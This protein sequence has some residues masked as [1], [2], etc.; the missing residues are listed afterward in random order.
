LTGFIF[1]LVMDFELVED[2]D[3]LKTIKAQFEATDWQFHIVELIS[4][5]TVRLQRNNTPNRLR[6]K[7]SK[8]NIEQSSINI[9]KMDKQH[10]M[11]SHDNELD[12]YSHIKI[13]NNNLDPD[14][15]ADQIIAYFNLETN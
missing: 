15:V 6:H 1:T 3:Y 8:S 7:P 2:W 5:Q 11:N 9:V 13:N 10:R 14:E 12:A 4:E